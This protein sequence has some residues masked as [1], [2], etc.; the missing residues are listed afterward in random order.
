[1]FLILLAVNTLMYLIP[2]LGIVG[3]IIMVFK[4]VWVSRQDPGDN[5]MQELAGFIAAG[6]LSFCRPL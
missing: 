5:N 3:L 4:A 1:M 6:A 2:V